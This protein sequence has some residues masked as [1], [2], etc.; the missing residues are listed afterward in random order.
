[1]IYEQNK[2]KTK[3]FFS[4]KITEMKNSLE[5]LKVFFFNLQL[6]SWHMEVPVPGTESKAQVHLCHCC[7]NAGSC[8]PLIQ[9]ADRIHTSKV[10]Q[11]TAVGFFF[12]KNYD[13]L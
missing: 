10:S 7:G 5:S 4:E 13:S 9:D 8:N 1:M 6:H 3:F 2:Q 12:R 11:V